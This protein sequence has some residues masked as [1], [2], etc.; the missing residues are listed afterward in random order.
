MSNFYHHGEQ[1]IED[2]GPSAVKTV[3]GW[4]QK[5]PLKNPPETISEDNTHSCATVNRISTENVEQLLVVYC[6]HD[7]LKD[8]CDDKA[9][10]SAPGGLCGH[11]VSP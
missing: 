4:I 1:L 2:N 8:L 11:S 5:N 7:F 10:M 3:L 6:K 9:E